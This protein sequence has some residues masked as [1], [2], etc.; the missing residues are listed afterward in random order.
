MLTR[1]FANISTAVDNF[2]EDFFDVHEKYFYNKETINKN[3]I[4]LSNKK[5]YTLHIIY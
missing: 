2:L 5:Q 3:F 4:H 1:Y